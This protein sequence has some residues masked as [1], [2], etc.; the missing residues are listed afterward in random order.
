MLVSIGFCVSL[1]DQ[2]YTC[3]VNSEIGIY[4][5]SVADNSRRDFAKL[6]LYTMGIKNKDLGRGKLIIK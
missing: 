5:L 4:F 3:L 6:H 2:V 1:F